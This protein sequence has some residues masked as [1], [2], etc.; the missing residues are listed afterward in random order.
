MNNRA[1][2]YH[3]VVD[4]VNEAVELALNKP[5]QPTRTAN[6]YLL[7]RM[8]YIKNNPGYSA[9]VLSPIIT[10]AW[11]NESPQTRQLYL[12]MAKEAYQQYRSI[13]NKSQQEPSLSQISLL[14]QVLPSQLS[15]LQILSLQQ[16]LQSSHSQSE[17]EE[18]LKCQQHPLQMSPPLRSSNLSSEMG[19]F[20]FTGQQF[21]QSTPRMSPPLQSETGDYLYP[22]QLQPPQSSN[23]SKTLLSHDMACSSTNIPRIINQP[24]YEYVVNAYNNDTDCKSTIIEYLHELQQTHANLIHLLTYNVVGEN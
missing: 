2:S 4:L 13:V 15:P 18:F 8:N 24:A 3:T 20:L 14:S 11:N 22:K 23:V 10:T 5:N 1:S 9:T 17:T 19:Y 21:Q 12:D 7:Y 16:S 6:A